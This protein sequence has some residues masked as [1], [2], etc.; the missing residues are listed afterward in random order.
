M[1]I[2]LLCKLIDYLKT[3]EVFALKTPHCKKGNNADSKKEP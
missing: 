2:G 3:A 1:H